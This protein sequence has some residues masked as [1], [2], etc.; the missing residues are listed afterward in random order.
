MSFFYYIAY[1][2]RN[3]YDTIQLSSKLLV[4]VKSEVEQ[5]SREQMKAIEDAIIEEQFDYE[6]NLMMMEESLSDTIADYELSN[7][8]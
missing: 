7:Q 8:W 5:M 4:L 6:L 3:G 1:Q 2:Y